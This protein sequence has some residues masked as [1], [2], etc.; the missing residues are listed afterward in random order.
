MRRAATRWII[1][2]L[3]VIVLSTGLAAE[4]AQLEHALPEDTLVLLSCRD[5]RG[6]WQGFQKTAI[7]KIWEEPEVQEFLRPVVQR[8]QQEIEKARTRSAEQGGPAAAAAGLLDVVPGHV[9]IA[10]LPPLPERQ[11]PIP[12]VAVLVEAH[13]GVDRIRALLDIGIQMAAGRAGAT[14]GEPF[15][16]RGVEINQI[17]RPPATIC[18]GFDGQRLVLTTSRQTM[19]RVLDGLRQPPADN[20]AAAPV[21]DSVARRLGRPRE[22]TLMLNIDSIF[23]SYEPMLQGMAPPQV[24]QT[25]QALYV[26]DIKSLVVASAIEPPGIR[27][28]VCI[29]APGERRGLAKLLAQPTG[30]KEL[31][32]H[33]PR[34]ALMCVG[35]KMD[36]ART[37]ATILDLVQEVHPPAHDQLLGQITAV[38]NEFGF[39]LREDLIE[40]LGDEAGLYYRFPAELGLMF[41][42]K[43]PEGI[44]RVLGSILGRAAAESS[45]R[46]REGEAG[47]SSVAF[48][49]HTVHYAPIKA[50]E[51]VLWPAYALTA[52][53]CVV[54]LNPQTVKSVL[55][56]MDGE[57]GPS[58]LDSP[59]F[60]EAA[61]RIP[62]RHVSLSY[63]DL[64]AMVEPAYDVAALVVQWA[65]DEHDMRE[66]IRELGLD[67]GRLPRKEV[68]ARH[69]FPAIECC[70]VDETGLWTESYSPFGSRGG[71]FN[72]LGT[73]SGMLLP[74]LAKARQQA[75]Q[76]T[77]LSNLKQLGLALHMYAADQ[78]GALPS[79]EQFPEALDP[80]V[81]DG[82]QL[83]YYPDRS[84]AVAGYPDNIDYEYDPGLR[85][86]LAEIDNP[87][88]TP[89]MWEKR[90]F[91]G[92]GS[93]AVLFVDGHVERL[94]RRSFRE[95]MREHQEE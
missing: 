82:R 52:D 69:L 67:L 70:T 72:L 6:S 66:P 64:P 41:G 18:Y 58:I 4:R 92:D 29:R 34:D 91:A 39:S 85:G 63:A 55:A 50:D 95:L 76:V 45:P 11:Q 12:E 16:H 37:Y 51:I 73:G 79:R 44:G 38:N 24:M 47:L 31:L 49:E 7:Y 28:V 26:K 27:E 35:S 80:Y 14:P 54:A 22:T 61:G 9:A 86:K 8:I 84:D 93:R 3:S 10:V 42:V 59:R 32:R 94:D 1:A 48:G 43:D 56:R 53:T 90:S 2:V 46:W 13:E 15:T 17:V 19:T 65:S 21:L 83:F 89:L 57:G 20:L 87:S 60:S 62:D 40:A 77:S 23:R 71:L 88:R 25:L 30:R 5:L 78:K 33:V 74:A 36:V 75:R 68:I 81:G